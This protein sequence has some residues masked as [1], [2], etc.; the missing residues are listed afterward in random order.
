VTRSAPIDGYGIEELTWEVQ[1]FPDGPF[2]NISGSIEKVH[3]ELL[4]INP[5]LDEDFAPLANETSISPAQDPAL[6]KRDGVTAI[7]QKTPRTAGNMPI[8]EISRRPSMV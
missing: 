5:N 4:K 7:A 2:L 8:M 6:Q 3:A 1:A